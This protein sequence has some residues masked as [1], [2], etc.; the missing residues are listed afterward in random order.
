MQAYFDSGG[1]SL[2][3]EIS[4]RAIRL[5]PD[6]DFENAAA[7]HARLE[8]LKPMLSQLP[9]IVGALTDWPESWCSASATPESRD[10]LPHRCR[11]HFRA[12]VRFRI[13]STEHA[14]SQSMESRVQE[15]LSTFP[16]ADATT[17]LETMEHLALLKRWYYRSTP[18]GRDF[19]RRCERRAPVCD[20]SC[21]AFRGF[22]AVKNQQTRKS[23]PSTVNT[24]RCGR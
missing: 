13:Q 9:E 19:L 5:P 4:S 10:L 2:V 3:R 14:K 22:I 16:P 18:G 6:L 8:K 23:V 11:T 7:L 1:Q 24:P 21:A 15:A 12:A 17:A 20:A